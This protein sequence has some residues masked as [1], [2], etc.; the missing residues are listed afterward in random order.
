MTALPASDR[1]G[2]LT[3]WPRRAKIT[4]AVLI[5]LLAGEGAAAGEAN[6][7]APT[8]P[9][10]TSDS[11]HVQHVQLDDL[12]RRDRPQARR[13]RRAP[14]TSTAPT[15]STSPATSTSVSSGGERAALGR[16]AIDDNARNRPGYL[17]ELFPT[18]LDLD[19]DGCDAREDTLIAES[20]VKATVGAGCHVLAGDWLS[21]YDGIEITDPSKLDVDHLVPLGEA[22]RSGAYRWNAPRRAAYANDVSES[23][24]LI[25]VT[26]A[27]NRSKSDSTPDQWRPPA[28]ASW[29]RYATA[30]VEVK[31]HWV[32]TV[33][34]TERDALGQMLDTC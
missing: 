4:V 22:W 13:P 29:C 6:E 14:P 25:A 30:W 28:Q 34:T 17:R 23:D 3:R 20:L 24:H 12:D 33:T 18:W 5:L 7:Q 32:L 27:S 16:L 8:E 10:P 31:R 11:Q 1:G 21:I 19:G 9:S 2:R 15:S 26:A